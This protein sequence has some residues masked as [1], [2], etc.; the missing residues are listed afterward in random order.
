MKANDEGAK[1]GREQGSRKPT[2]KKYSC[3]HQCGKK[4]CIFHGGRDC[5]QKRY[6][7]LN[8]KPTASFVPSRVQIPEILLLT[9][10]L[11]MDRARFSRAPI[12]SHTVEFGNVIPPQLQ[13]IT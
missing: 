5:G 10:D 2:M 4:Y 13:V 6:I 12:L 11:R 7:L 8:L 9:L 1:A 3:G